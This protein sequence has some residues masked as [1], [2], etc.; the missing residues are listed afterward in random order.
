MQTYGL[1]RFATIQTFGSFT[2]H[3]NNLRIPYRHIILF[4]FFLILGVARAQDYTIRDIKINPNGE[5]HK[6]KN[7][8][9]MDDD[10]FLWY[11]TFNG[12]VKDFGSYN[13]I[14]PFI[15]KNTDN[16]P[17]LIHDFF[18]DSKRRVWVSGT[19][20]IFVSSETLDVSSNRI[21]FKLFLKGLELQ[22]NSFIEDCDGNLWIA[23]G[24]RV[25]NIILKV[26]SSLV[27]TEY[28]VPGIEP[29]Y[30]D[31]AYFLRNFLQFERMIDCDKFLIRQGRK[32]FVLDKGKA[33]LI[34]D[35]TSTLNYFHGG[36]LHPEWQ[37][38]GGDGLL[39]TDNGDFLSESIETQYSYEGSIFKTHFIKDLD[40]QVLS[41]PIQ[42]M[43][44]IKEEDNPVLKNHADLIGIED[45][46]KKLSL[47]KMMEMNGSLHLKKTY[48]IPFPNLIDDIEID[49][50]GIIYV[51]SDDHISKIKFSKNNFSRILNYNEGQRID[52]RGFLEL[53]NKEILA[54]TDEGV[55]KLTPSDDPYNKSPYETAKVFDR[56]ELG[57]QKSFLKVSDSTAWCL[58]ESN[59]LVKINYIKNKIEE[60]HLFNSHWRLPSLHYYDLLQSSDSTLLLSS[61]YGLHEFNTEQN[62]FRELPIPIVENNR[63]LFIWD[64][65]R[66]KNR[67]FIGT[68][69]NGLIIKYIDSDTFLQLNN[70][71]TEGKLAL[72]SNKVNLIFVDRQENIWLGTDKGAVHIDKN[73]KELTVINEAHGLT[74]LNVLGILEDID[75]NLWFSTRNGLYQYEKDLKKITSFYV[76][77]GLPFNDFNPSSYYRSSSGN[78]FFGGING[79]ITFD[80]VAETVQSQEI[81]IFPTKF[82]YYDAQEEKE[83]KLD[84]IDKDTHSFNLP[85]DKSSFSISYTINDCYNTDANKYAYRLDGVTDDWVN[86]GSQ[87][88][89]K[90]LSIP[91]GN[92]VLRIKGLNSTGVES[93]DELVYDLNI[94]E[95]FYKQSWFL[96]LS[97]FL[98]VGLLLFLVLS[99]GNKVKKK[100]AL[101]LALIELERK[102]LIS[103]MN[104][105]FIFNALNE[106]RNRLRNDRTK[107]LE[108]Y[109]TLFSKLTRL[110]L[111][112]T[113]NER[114]QLSKEIDFIKSYVTLSNIDNAIDVTLIV[115]CE[116]DIDLDDLVIPPMILQPIIENSIIHGFT[117]NQTEKKIV[118]KIKKS[119]LSQQLIFSVEDNGLGIM[120]TKEMNGDQHQSYASQ[121]LKERLNLMNQINQ[122]NGEYEIRFQ[123]L[124]DGQKSGTRVI[125]RIP[126]TRI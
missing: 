2:N 16:L 94:A 4:S 13:V 61:H 98:L 99:Y 27:V 95:V 79:L 56:M 107:G 87:T 51:S 102:T 20:G 1:L 36:Y 77:D 111:D 82:E 89:L 78:L 41:L 126:Y 58:G 108:H 59:K 125:V 8:M 40:I 117:E 118:L 46:G 12:F 68:D 50:N 44:L 119:S 109:V 71:S 19:T 74:N 123:D 18:I 63:E 53:P 22:A 54:A 25:D 124:T 39:I 93:I 91:P 110:T 47:F 96:I 88:T 26:D 97:G 116:A 21:E 42:E 29:R 17:K 101:N 73:L 38:N 85:Y 35:F 7:F 80:S 64:L 81:R 28:K 104:P 37:H 72:P 24:A 57:Y 15:D 69:A 49:K 6:Y 11:S 60:V 3:L 30:A 31:D 48:E 114:I 103:Q 62:K 67:L 55:F 92:H 65:H 100:Y 76:E 23:A 86:L 34:A 112:V 113:R 84:V 105:H 9:Q 121:I 115:K 45:L 122:R 10:G 66:A 43:I 32:L 75:G 90:L 33:T 120:T 106:I 14:S 52:V 70:D 83:M 5:S